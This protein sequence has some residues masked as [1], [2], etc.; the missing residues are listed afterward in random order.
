V[1]D[2]H[3]ILV[4]TDFSPHAEH[5]LETAIGLARKLGASILLLHSYRIP[6]RPVTV[7]DLFFP[8]GLWGEIHAAAERKMNQEVAKVRSQ[9]V[10]V[11]VELTLE[12]PAHA[13]LEALRAGRAQLV[14]MGTHGLRGVRRLVLGSVAER[15][16]HDAPVPVVLVNL[17]A[18]APERE[19]P[20]P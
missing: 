2:I 5:A 7:Y 12:P 4:P 19:A 1:Q 14:V 10:P 11:E 3:T 6:M 17:A 8:A 13:A 20:A 18:G 9:G 15:V 16:V